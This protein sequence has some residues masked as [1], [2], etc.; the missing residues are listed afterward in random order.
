MVR[1]TLFAFFMAAQLTSWAQTTGN[2]EASVNFMD[3]SRIISGFVPTSY[4]STQQYKLF[5]GLHGLGDNSNN[6]RSAIINN[7]WDDIFDQTIFLCPDGGDDGNSDFNVPAGDE[8]IIQECINYALDNYNIDTTDIILQGFSLGGRAAMKY[9]LNHPEKFKGLMLNTPAIQGVND[10]LNTMADSNNVDFEY[11]NADQIPMFITIGDQDDLYHYTLNAVYPIL[12]KNNGQLK[13]EVIAGLGHS[14]PSN[15]IMTE[16]MNFFNQT[17]PTNFDVDLFEIS[18]KKRFCGSDFSPEFIVRNIGDSTV[19]TLDINYAI[20]GTDYSYTWNG[21]MLSFDHAVIQ[22]PNHTLSDGNHSLDIEIGLINQS[23]VD[24]QAANNTLNKSFTSGSA[25]YEIDFY[26]DFENDNTD[27]VFEENFNVF[28]WDINDDASKSGEYALSNFNCPLVFD[29]KG[30]VESVETPIINFSNA[31][32]NHRVL[33]FDLAYNYLKYTPPFVT[34]TIYFADTLE[35]FISTDCGE[36]YESIF[37]KGGYAL[38][39]SIPLLNPTTIANCIFTPTDNEWEKMEIDLSSYSEAEEVQ[40]KFSYES[41]M[42]GT[43]YVDN[44]QVNTQPLDIEEEVALNLN[45][46]PNPSSDYLVVEGIA[47]DFQ[48]KIF[49]IHGRMVLLESNLQGT[50]VINTSKL[51]TGFYQVEIITG[52]K[53]MI[54]QIVI[55]N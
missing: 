9:G 20:D 38:G 53:R 11:S 47:S 46:S 22:L 50:S 39:T 2:I 55:S 44:V 6:Y 8:A 21:N 29:T 4:D 37:R 35:I 45:L 43:I 13:Y 48:I 40:I 30:R 17:T 32:S 31:S 25:N 5:V 15:A 18:N 24:A 52:E 7:G 26:T 27:W 49:D 14:I 42:G 41:A 12:K 34:E 3:E 51:I 36:T 1:I 28:E 16:G 23:Q 54:E 33:S 10:A 19:T